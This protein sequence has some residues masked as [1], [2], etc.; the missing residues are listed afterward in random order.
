MNQSRRKGMLLKWTGSVLSAFFMI[1]SFQAQAITIEHAKGVTQFA[2]TPKRVVA[3]G[4]ASLDVLDKLGIKPVATPHAML[5]EYLAGYRS[6]T[7]NAG[8]F[9]EPDFE[10]IFNAKPDVIVVEKRMMKSYNQL[11]KIAPTIVF[12]LSGDHY[13]AET[14]ANWRMLG[15]LFEKE[16][17]VEAYI[18]KLQQQFDAIHNEVAERQ[19]SS[20][21]LMNNGS[22]VAMFGKGSR[23]TVVFDEFGFTESASSKEASKPTPHGNLIS[24]EY[25]FDA[26]PDVI[27]VIDRE[28]AIGKREGH[29]KVMFDN[30]LVNA[31][32]AGQNQRVIF[33][34]PNAWYI[35]GGGIT[36]TES[37]LND[38]SSALN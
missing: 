26:K 23:F 17:Q 3:L 4:N 15:K 16:Q 28:Q 31:T 5:P 14:Q 32:P 22:Q 7:V 6:N 30:K 33:V 10:A 36:A 34:D 13:W 2:A 29:A 20:L 12:D 27:F 9:F 21:M 11:R 38:V 35:S 1:M 37:M 19:L 8:A 24:F 25:I 18:S